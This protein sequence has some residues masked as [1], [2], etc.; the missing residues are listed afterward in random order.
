M[1]FEVKLKE[2]ETIVTELEGGSLSL[3]ESITKFEQGINLS[4]ECT[5]SLEEAEKKINI[6]TTTS[7]ENMEEKNFEIEE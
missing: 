5:K 2:L 1:S 6:L 4:K 3:E 7:G